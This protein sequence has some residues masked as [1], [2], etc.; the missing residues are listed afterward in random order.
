M[1]VVIVLCN[2]FLRR[3]A[4]RCVLA[5]GML[6][7]VNFRGVMLICIAESVFGNHAPGISSIPIV[8]YARAFL[9]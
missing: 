3:T 9:F 6:S 4:S 7:I 5:S 1:V 2:Y 8:T